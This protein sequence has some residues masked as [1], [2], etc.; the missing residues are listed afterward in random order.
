MTFQKGFHY[1]LLAMDINGKVYDYFGGVD[2][3]KNKVIGRS[4]WSSA[5]GRPIGLMRAV[6]FAVNLDFRLHVETKAGIIENN[7]LIKETAAE[8]TT[9]SARYCPAAARPRG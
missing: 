1:E 9:S 7:H 5:S 2:D 4:A 3:I 8:S 6:R